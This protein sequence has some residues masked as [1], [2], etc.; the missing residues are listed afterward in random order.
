VTKIN[1]RKEES[2]TDKMPVPSKSGSSPTSAKTRI[3]N[4]VGF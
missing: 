2:M 3:C 4:Q 1:Y